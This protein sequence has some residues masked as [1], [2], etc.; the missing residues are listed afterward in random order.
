[1]DRTHLVHPFQRADIADRIV[2]V[3]GEGCT[4]WDAHGTP[5]LDATGGGNPGTGW[6]DTYNFSGGA[7]NVTTLTARTKYDHDRLRLRWCSSQGGSC[8]IP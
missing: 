5:Y 3:R 4:V 6:G 7:P 2:I 8:S 1:L